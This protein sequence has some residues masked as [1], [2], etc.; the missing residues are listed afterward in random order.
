MLNEFNLVHWNI[1]GNTNSILNVIKHSFS[2]LYPIV[3][4][5]HE[6]DNDFIKD[7]HSE[8]MQ[9]GTD[10][11]VLGKAKKS[12]ILTNIQN[13]KT[14]IEFIGIGESSFKH[15]VV[16][17]TIKLS[18]FPIKILTFH[19]PIGSVERK[20]VSGTK[21]KALFYKK[22]LEIIRIEKPDIITMDANEP[23]VYGF[24]K[25]K[26]YEN[27]LTKDSEIEAEVTFEYIFQNFTYLK[28]KP[29]YLKHL[30]NKKTI[31]MY[32][33]H[34][35]YNAKIIKLR[36]TNVLNKFLKNH[37]SDHQYIAVNVTLNSKAIR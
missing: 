30:A 33:D 10:L 17:T 19:S 20:G 15:R 14:K 8:F 6:V 35:F 23:E 18:Q 26:F 27:S 37:K 7:D 28:Y 1:R 36:K 29:T 34:V 32:Y 21:I 22:I 4:C 3:F 24:Q 12:N 13:Q 16:K 31:G 2:T 11:K 9:K 5:L 25:W